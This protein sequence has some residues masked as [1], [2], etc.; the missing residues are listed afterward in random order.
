MAAETR[1]RR[2]QIFI[3]GGA[4]KRVSSVGAKSSLEHWLSLGNELLCRS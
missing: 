2:S 3:A 4:N 1:L